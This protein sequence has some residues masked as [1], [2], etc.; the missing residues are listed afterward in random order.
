[1]TRIETL[2]LMGYSEAEAIERATT[3]TT[4]RIAFKRTKVTVTPKRITVDR[5]IMNDKPLEIDLDARTSPNTN[6]EPVLVYSG[7]KFW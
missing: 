6:D 3:E 5:N 2:K 4:A 1:M 7:P